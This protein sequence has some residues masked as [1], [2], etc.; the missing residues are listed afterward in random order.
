MFD[1]P[2]RFLWFLVIA[3][4]SVGCGGPDI[5]A[6]CQEQEKC[7]GG[8]EADI[9]ACIAAFEGG[10]ELA[11]DIGCGDEFDE[12]WTC[13]QENASCR[14]VNTGANC[15][16]DNECGNE[17]GVRCNGGQCVAKVY[18]FD[19]ALSESPCEPQENAYQR[20]F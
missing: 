8:N 12:F 5:D 2:G 9:N 14:D 18:G 11:S 16:T 20:C 17:A 3:V 15:M 10:D 13:Q 4:A 19:P 6:L 7:I 1:R